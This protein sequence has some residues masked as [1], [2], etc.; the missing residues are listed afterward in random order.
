MKKLLIISL[1]LISLTI[2]QLGSLEHAFHEHAPGEQCD[3]CLSAKSLGH[4][5]ITTLLIVAG[6]YSITVEAASPL[7]LA[8]QPGHRHYS[9]RAPPL[10]C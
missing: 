5:L 7:L 4:G 9:V 6:G 10:T 3:Y 1:A 2:G 8:G